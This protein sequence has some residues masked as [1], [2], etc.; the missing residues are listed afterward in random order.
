MNETWTYNGRLIT[1]DDER[2][3]YRKDMTHEERERISY[4]IA[5]APDLLRACQ[6]MI[7]ANA[8][9]IEGD[10]D[11]EADMIDAFDMMESAVA[12][13][14]CKPTHECAS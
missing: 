13:A 11:S 6:R 4:L 2:P 3:I 1:A 14:T 5:A 8:D 7:A 9:F 12:K 10:P